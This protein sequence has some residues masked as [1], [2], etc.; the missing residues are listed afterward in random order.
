MQLGGVLI[1]EQLER[2]QAHTVERREPPDVSKP[3]LSVRCDGPAAA[4]P[5]QAARP[6][7]QSS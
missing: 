3:R 2:G 7:Q 4:R 1:D 5:R 6:P